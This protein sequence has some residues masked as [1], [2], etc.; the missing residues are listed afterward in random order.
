ME[1]RVSGIVKESI[2]DGPGIRYVV[3]VQGCPHGCPGCHN[4]GTHSFEGGTIMT[5]EEIFS[6]I[7]QNPLLDGV[8]FSGG[9]PLCQS[10]ALAELAGM[11]HSIGLNVIT[12]TGYIFECLMLHEN[13]VPASDRILHWKELVNNSDYLIDGPFVESK[14]SYDLL[15]RGSSNQR[16]LDCK[17]S[18]L[19]GGAYVIESFD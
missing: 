4:P 2:T 11:V 16:I 3:F 6:E 17:K 18:M 9:E 8:T 14:K 12:Y 15:F 10:E 5:T 19:Y 1:L 7:K 13:L